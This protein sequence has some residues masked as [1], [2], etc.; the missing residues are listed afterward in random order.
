MRGEEGELTA[1]AAV[2]DGDRE[3]REDETG[4]TAAGAGVVG[5]AVDAADL[6]GCR[7]DALFV[8]GVPAEVAVLG[9][10]ADPAAAV[11]TSAPSTSSSSASGGA[12]LL[13][14]VSSSVGSNGN[15]SL[16]LL[17]IFVSLAVVSR[18]LGR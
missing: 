8:R 2:V 7:V 6:G 10:A 13:N 9:D 1:A 15:P 18:F 5:A 16:A 12:S 14:S 3:E 17:S 11:A 4:A